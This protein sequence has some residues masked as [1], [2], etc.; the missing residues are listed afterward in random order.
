MSC[1]AVN[2]SNG[3]TSRIFRESVEVTGRYPL[4][5]GVLVPKSLNIQYFERIRGLHI[6]YKRY[7]LQIFIAWRGIFVL[8]GF[9]MSSRYLIGK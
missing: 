1:Y 5:I 3:Q 2:G 8:L 7:R 4:K 9:Q 6:M